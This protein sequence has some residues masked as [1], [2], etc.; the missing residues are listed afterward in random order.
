MQITNH[1]DVRLAFANPEI[2][3]DGSGSSIGCIRGPFTTGVMPDGK[4]TGE[5][6]HVRQIEENPSNFFTDVHSSLAVPGATRGQLG[7]K[8]C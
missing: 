4:D 1:D 8:Q 3:P 2:G 7:D 5:G 6:F